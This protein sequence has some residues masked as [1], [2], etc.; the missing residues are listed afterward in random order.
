MLT[1]LPHT[2]G[3]PCCGESYLLHSRAQDAAWNL[4]FH[5]VCGGFLAVSTEQQRG[6]AKTHR[7]EEAWQRWLEY[8]TTLLITTEVLEGIQRGR[9]VKPWGAMN[10]AWRT[11]RLIHQF[12]APF[13]M[14]LLTSLT[15]HAP[16]DGRAR[17]T[18]RK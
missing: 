16:N 2:L 1:G 17:Q 12:G 4:E 18:S 5:P 13:G 9:I 15:I 8:G 11:D 6:M 3:T 7:S 14:A 10:A